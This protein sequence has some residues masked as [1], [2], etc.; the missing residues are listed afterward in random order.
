MADSED[1]FVWL[2]DGRKRP[3]TEPKRKNVRHLQPFSKVAADLLDK[4]D[5]RSVTN[6]EIRAAINALC[7]VKEGC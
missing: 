2:A 3:A 1:G 7:K 5:G 6:E 4:A